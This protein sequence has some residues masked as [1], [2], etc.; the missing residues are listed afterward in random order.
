[1]TTTTSAFAGGRYEATREL[2][3]GGMAVVYLAHD[4]ELDRP[5]AV[6]VL[7]GHVGADPELVARFRREAMTAARLAHANVV[8]V[9]DAGEDEGRL[10]IV[11]EYVEGETLDGIAAREGRL[12]PDRVLELA[13]QACAGLGYAHEHGVVHRDVKPANLLLRPDGVLKVADFGIAQAADATRMTAVGTVLGTA[14]YVAPEQAR[15]DPVG[16]PADVFSLGVVLYRLFTGVLPW[17]VESLAELASVGETPARPLRER[18]P[19]VSEATEAALMR[20]LARNPAYRHANASELGA[21]LAAAAAG[22]PDVAAPTT[23]RLRRRREPS[24]RPWLV[25]LAALAAAAVLVAALAVALAGRDGA[26]EPVRIEPV[27]PSD[28]AAEQ[29]R[30]LERWLREHAQGD[31]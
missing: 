24:R 7:D 28:D 8:R 4:R 10:W 1:M 18:A 21:E 17:P 2:G 13:A 5:V 16:P 19:D 27:P 25:A 6:K 12:A 26:A 3:R 20:A 30:E 15:G 9:Y 31:G 29:A 11:M 22:A 14:A 23:A